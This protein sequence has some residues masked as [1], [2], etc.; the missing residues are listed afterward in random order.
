MK[1]KIRY[2]AV[3]A[4]RNEAAKLFTACLDAVSGDAFRQLGWGRKRLQDM[5]NATEETLFEV[6]E[7]SAA[8]DTTGDYSIDCD[9]QRMLLD[10]SVTALWSMRRT[11]MECGYDFFKEDERLMWSDPYDTKWL[12]PSLASV[13]AARLGWCKNTEYMTRPYILTVLLHARSKGYGAERLG[14]LHKLIRTKFNE[15]VQAWLLCTVDADKRCEDTIQKKLEELEA[16]GVKTM[17][18]K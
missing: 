3:K 10:A 12:P 6:I 9:N 7:R 5:F 1:C 4:E 13:H 8:A 14:T 2:N 11:L 15:F 16:I 18:L 17:Q